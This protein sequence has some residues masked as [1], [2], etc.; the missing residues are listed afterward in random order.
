MQR[1]LVPTAGL[2]KSPGHYLGVDCGGTGTRALVGNTAGETLGEGLGGPCNPNLPETQTSIASLRLAVQGALSAASVQLPDLAGIFVGMAGTGGPAEL[3]AGRAILTAA[4]LAGPM[5]IELDTDLRIALAGGLDGKPGIVLIAGTGSGCYGRRDDGRSWK[6]G[7]WGHILDDGGSGYGLAH[8]GLCAAVRI[9]D[10]RLPGSPLLAKLLTAL[11]LTHL[12]QMVGLLH[13]QKLTK[14]EIAALARPVLDAWQS[15]DPV[16]AQII[17]QGADQLA[18]LVQAVARHLDL[19]EPRVC[20]AGGMLENSVAY[21]EQVIQAITTRLPRAT[22]V[23]P[24]HSPVVGALLLA[25]RGN[26]S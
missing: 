17:R 1:I 5:P 6:A 11:D 23:P 9:A 15:G 21:R 13:Q 16:A 10:G 19:S 8:A 22:V 2:T 4:G 24:I 14:A 26:K 20:W 18:E 12:R 7:G 3:E 25:R